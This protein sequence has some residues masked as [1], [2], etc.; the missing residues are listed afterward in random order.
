MRLDP[1]EAWYAY[2][3]GAAKERLAAATTDVHQRRKYLIAALSLLRRAQ[4]IEPNH[5]FIQLEFATAYTTLAD[6]VDPREFPAAD[7]AWRAF[8]DHDPTN[9]E[10]RLMHAEMLENWAHAGGGQQAIDAARSE[11]ARVAAMRHLEERGLKKVG[12]VRARLDASN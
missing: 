8:I 11:V 7:Q 12:E 3:A 5:P 6:K 2:Y 4:R 9:W 1:R 10:P